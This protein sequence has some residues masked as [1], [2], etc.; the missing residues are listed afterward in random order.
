MAQEKPDAQHE[1]ARALG[2]EALEALSKGKD[3]DASRKIDKAK[4]LDS[5]AL[6]ELV[7]DL[8]DDAASDHDIARKLPD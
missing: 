1:Q 2:E 8:D 5:S 3:G 7:E 4:Q 6:E